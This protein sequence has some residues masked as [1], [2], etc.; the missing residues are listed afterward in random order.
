MCGGRS[1]FEAAGLTG[2]NTLPRGCRARPCPP[3]PSGQ[4]RNGTHIASVV[5]FCC[6]CL[7]SVRA[8]ELWKRGPSECVAR[9]GACTLLLLYSHC[10]GMVEA[11]VVWPLSSYS[12][13]PATLNNI[14]KRSVACHASH[15]GKGEETAFT[16]TF[17]LSLFLQQSRKMQVATVSCRVCSPPPLSIYLRLRTQ[18][19]KHIF[20]HLHLA[21]FCS[22]HAIPAIMSHLLFLLLAFFSSF[23]CSFFLTGEFARHG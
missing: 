5:P 13:T 8:E 6:A 1:P 19:H 21:Q 16:V 20:A 10:R 15:Q 23:F 14:C 3:S 17:L 4:Q 18:Q 11:T 7:P 22:A 2:C 12:R 9:G